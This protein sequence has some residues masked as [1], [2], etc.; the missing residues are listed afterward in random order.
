MQE[1]LPDHVIALDYVLDYLRRARSVKIA[2]EVGPTARCFYAAT[3]L[4]ANMKSAVGRYNSLAA[5]V[6][7]GD[8]ATARLHGVQPVFLPLS[9]YGGTD[10]L[11]VAALGH[12]V[13]HGKSISEPVL[14][15]D[16]ALHAIE[17]AAELAPL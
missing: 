9:S 6:L 12:R 16:A 3:T 13:V 11:Q 14:I 5:R 8:S 4:R 15:D 1:P 17:D 2:E 10:G 7:P